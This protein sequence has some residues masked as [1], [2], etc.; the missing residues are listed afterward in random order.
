MQNNSNGVIQVSNE[1]I[2][3]QAK[4]SNKVSKKAG[5]YNKHDRNKRRKEV[6]RLYFDLGYSAVK[7]SEMM[8]INRNTINLDIKYWNKS[9]SKEWQDNE[10][11]SWIMKQIIRLDI[12]RDR[13]RKYL[14]KESEIKNK[15]KIEKMIFDIDYQITQIVIRFA[16]SEDKLY[17][18]VCKNYN[19]AAKQY[20]L[21]EAII[22]GDTIVGTSHATNEKIW[23][24][25]EED[26]NQL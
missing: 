21:P 22:Y 16:A 18:L 12:Q 5:P 8:K 20:K 2:N 7:I 3:E 13:L 23:K 4:F 26:K 9:L 11:E 10:N 24:L 19:I 6:F 14:G 1:F 17:E 25:I 15:L